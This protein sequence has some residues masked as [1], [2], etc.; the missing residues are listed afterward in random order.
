MYRHLT[1]KPEQQRFTVRS[2]VLSINSIMRHMMM[3]M[4]M[5]MMM[6]IFV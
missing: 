5:M 4:V 1:R 3:M 6:F 2:G